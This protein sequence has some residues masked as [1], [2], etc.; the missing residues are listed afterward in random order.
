MKGV[1]KME[2]KNEGKQERVIIR[3]AKKAG[4]IA[5]ESVIAQLEDPLTYITTL[6]MV[7]GDGLIR[8]FDL[9]R[10]LKIGLGVGTSMIGSGVIYNIVNNLG[11]IDEA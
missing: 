4:E 11:T 10:G 6:G 1:I 3:K 5:A 2:N 9:R 7:F 8:G